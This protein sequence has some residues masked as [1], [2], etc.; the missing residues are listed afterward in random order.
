[1]ALSI[2]SKAVMVSSQTGAV[3]RYFAAH[4]LQHVAGGLLQLGQLFSFGLQDA[5]V[6]H[7]GDL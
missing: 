3:Q 6:V 4:L 7:V 1:M 2:K 5:L